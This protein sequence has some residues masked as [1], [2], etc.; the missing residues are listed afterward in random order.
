VSTAL[1]I[2][3]KNKRGPVLDSTF[4][5]QSVGN[6][7]S[8]ACPASFNYVSVT[9]VTGNVYVAF[10]NTT[11]TANASTDPRAWIPSGS[12]LS[13]SCNV[14]TTVSVTDG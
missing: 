10:G 6:A 14:G 12:T 11:V 2:F 3:G 13:S 1:V 7:V 9:A 4:T 5:S 8:N